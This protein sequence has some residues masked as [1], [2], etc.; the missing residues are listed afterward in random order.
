MNEKIE[1]VIKDNIAIIRLMDPENFNP[2][3]NSRK[4]FSINLKSFL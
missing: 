1:L 2:L 3:I 4:I